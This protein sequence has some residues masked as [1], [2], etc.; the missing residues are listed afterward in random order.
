MPVLAGVGRR[1][2][3]YVVHHIDEAPPEDRMGKR[4]A[5]T[6]DAGECHTW[7]ALALSSLF[8]SG[9]RTLARASDSMATGLQPTRKALP[10]LIP[11]GLPRAS[12]CKQPWW[13][14]AP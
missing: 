1:S 5:I 14:G 3:V 8:P 13:Y 12:T 10:Q 11:D 7:E 2:C 4:V 9:G 6:T